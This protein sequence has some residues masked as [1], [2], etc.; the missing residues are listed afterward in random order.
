M[1]YIGF[2]KQCCSLMCSKYISFKSWC[3]FQINKAPPKA[4][5]TILIKP[6]LLTNW[7]SKSSD[8]VCLCF[9]VIFL[10]EDLQLLRYQCRLYNNHVAK[11]ASKTLSHQLFW[12]II[13]ILVLTGTL[14]YYR[15]KQYIILVAS[16]VQSCTGFISTSLSYFHTAV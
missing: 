16:S 12:W 8:F 13:L 5:K 3:I 7:K 15:I 1:Q 2:E 6:I 10:T 4:R 11:E 14:Q 9:F